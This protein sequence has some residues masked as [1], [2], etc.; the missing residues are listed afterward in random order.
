M[1]LV[2]DGKEI[3]RARYEETNEELPVHGIPVQ[4]GE[5]CVF[6][7]KVMRNAIK[8][9]N[10][11]S[12]I[13]C[14]GSAFLWSKDEL[15]RR[16]A[17]ISINEMGTQ[18]RCLTPTESRKRKREPE[19]WKRNV[20]KKAYNSSQ[21]YSHVVNK[22]DESKLTKTIKKRELK[23]PFTEKCKLKCQ[24]SFPEEVRRKIFSD[25]YSAG[26]KL[27]QS[28]QIARLV[29]QH[30]KEQARTKDTNVES[31]RNYSRVYKLLVN[32]NPVRVRQTMFL[33]TLPL[34][35]RE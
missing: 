24:D 22:A 33:S 34:T 32:G 5:S 18:A 15:I 29:S 6:I 10:V 35:K 1:Y 31:R 12:Y 2:E 4:P 3:F 23:P 30:Q 8:W 13:M 27:L 19:N 28:Q 14:Q 11:N 16:P 7:I 25:F 26:D 17:P 21:E 9:K 20:M